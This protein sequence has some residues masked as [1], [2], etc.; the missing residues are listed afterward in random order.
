MQT[1][2]NVNRGFRT[3]LGFG[4]E[5][6]LHQAIAQLTM[7]GALACSLCVLDSL[8]LGHC[9]GRRCIQLAAE[10]SASGKPNQASQ[11]TQITLVKSKQASQ[12]MQVRSGKSQQAERSSK[13]EQGQIKSGKLC[14]ESQIRQAADGVIY[15]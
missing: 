2:E 13:S 5:C 3:R 14:Q 12:I 4:S 15:L 10:G 7:Q 8:L 1:L 6:L 11:I 9:L